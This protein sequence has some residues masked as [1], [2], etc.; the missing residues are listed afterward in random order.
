ML[1]VLCIECGFISNE[2][3]KVISVSVCR[4]FQ[5]AS[6]LPLCSRPQ[7]V[8][9]NLPYFVRLEAG[10]VVRIRVTIRLWDVDLREWSWCC[11]E[12]LGRVGVLL[13][14]VPGRWMG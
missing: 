8:D 11:W 1:D 5:T 13:F 7:L 12:E 3:S 6:K 4:Y 9:T 2:G 14:G 10:R